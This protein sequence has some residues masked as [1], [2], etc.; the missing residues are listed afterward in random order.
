MRAPATA[1]FGYATDGRR[2]VLVHAG[3]ET[4]AHVPEGASVVLMS[5]GILANVPVGR[6]TA[7]AQPPEPTTV[8][9][10]AVIPVRADGVSVAA[11]IVAEVDVSAGGGRVPATGQAR[12]EL[13]TR[14]LWETLWATGV[15][16]PL[17]AL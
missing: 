17:S 12:V 4:R 11:V 1:T 8:P 7:R 2:V 9:L 5:S 6:G 14:N 15:L 10:H 13:G 3:D 16:A